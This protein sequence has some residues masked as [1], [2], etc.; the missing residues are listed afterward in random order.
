[1]VT[2]KH[3]KEWKLRKIYDD[4]E[5]PKLEISSDE[6]QFV[7]PDFSVLSPERD[8]RLRRL[9]EVAFEVNL[10]ACAIESWRKILSER[11][12]EDEEVDE[13]RKD[14][15]DTPV[16]IAQ[17]IRR[18]IE[19]GK[20]SVSSLVP[21][22]RRYFERLVGA[23]DG[24]ATIKDY[25]AK[26]GKALFKQL[27]TWQPYEGLLLG[28]FLSSHSSMTDEIVIDHLEVEDLKCAFGFLE[29]YGDKI[30]QLGAIEVAL[31]TLPERPEIQPLIIPLIEQIRD[32]NIETVARGLKL[33]SALFVLVDGELSRTRLLS[34]APPFYRRLASLSHAALIHRQLVNSGVDDKFC[35]WAVKSRGNQFYWQSLT[36]MRQEPR[37]TPDFADATQMKA[38]FF[39]RIMIAARKYKTNIK[40][41]EIH[42]LILGEGTDSLQALSE[43]PY[44]YLPGPLEGME[45]H[46]INLPDDISQMI[47]K[48]LNVNEIESS[49][50]NILINSAMI[51]RVDSDHAKLA[52]NALKLGNYHL[53]NVEDKSQL[54]SILDGLAIIAATA[55]NGAL[56]DELRILVRRYRRDALFSLS[57]FEIV[58][59]GLIAGASHSDLNKWRGFTGEWLTELALGELTNDEGIELYSY[60]QNLCHIVPELWVSC[61]R[62]DAALK[63]FIN[64]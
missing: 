43:F 45:N 61:S 27:L 37:W 50:F 60:L 13:F 47:E 52:A 48:N 36:D 39:G 46:P 62:S 4:S 31:R 22:S 55:R 30:S 18:E 54:I 35:K 19:T 41:S 51:F 8:I 5:L 24:S 42:N 63:A 58:R 57:I 29:K 17:S 40:G 9:D 44:H 32:D 11:A 1:V 38:D 10:P 59:I 23:C 14:I 2:D 28:L 21:S 33:F 34:D 26:S 53:N 49:S 12:L 15:L 6:Q 64:H 56:A 20:S 16:Q 7:L 25:A 3:G